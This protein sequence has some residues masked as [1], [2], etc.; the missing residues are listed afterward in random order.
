MGCF[1]VCEV[2]RSWVVLRGE[3]WNGG[4]LGGKL[5]GFD[6]VTWVTECTRVPVIIIS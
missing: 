6:G 2:R 3:G 4:R 1:G 5:F